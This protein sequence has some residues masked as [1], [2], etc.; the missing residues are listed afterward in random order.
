MRERWSETTLGEVAIAEGAR[1]VQSSPER[2]PS[3]SAR[4]SPCNRAYGIA[5]EARIATEQ[6]AAERG[7]MVLVLDALDQDARTS[8]A[9]ILRCRLIANSRG[10]AHGNLTRSVRSV[11]HPRVGVTP[12]TKSPPRSSR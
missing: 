11:E 5:A 4:A 10:H 1:S 8:V 6:S 2:N 12:P 7:N 3:T 9:T